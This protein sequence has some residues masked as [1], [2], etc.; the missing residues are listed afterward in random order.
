MSSLTAE[1][2]VEHVTALVKDHS[3]PSDDPTEILQAALDLCRSAAS[4]LEQDLESREP[5]AKRRRK[6][7]AAAEA[8]ATATAGSS[9]VS[10]SLSAPA[11][12]AVSGPST[13]CQCLTTP[14]VRESEVAEFFEC[15]KGNDDDFKAGKK[16]AMRKACNRGSLVAMLVACRWLLKFGDWLPGVCKNPRLPVACLKKKVVREQGISP[17]PST[18][19]IRVLPT[20]HLFRPFSERR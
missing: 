13:Q 9:S 20:A 16:E 14:M 10:S 15:L 2:V 5:P 11:P 8:A 6:T 17:G 4:L 1:R 12:A 18:S 7:P 3:S 19:P